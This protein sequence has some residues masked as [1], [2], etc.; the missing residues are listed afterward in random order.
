MGLVPKIR[1]HGGCENLEKDEII[2]MESLTLQIILCTSC[3]VSIFCLGVIFGAYLISRRDEKMFNYFV[4]TC[5]E[6]QKNDMISVDLTA[7][8]FENES[9]KNK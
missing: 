5:T 2:I 7:N 8:M 4:S 9:K 3:L 1:L 6:E